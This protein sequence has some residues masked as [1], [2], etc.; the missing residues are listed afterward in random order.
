MN[1]APILFRCDATPDLSW[2]SFYQCMVLANAIQRRRR[3]TWFL[4]RLEP[5]SLAVTI[6]RGGHEWN[7]T[8]TMLGTADDLDATLREIR[9]LSAAAVVVCGH[10]LNEEYLREL[11]AAGVLVVVV[12][13]QAQV[14][15]PN[16]LVINPFLGLGRE[17]YQFE[18]GTQLLLGSRF[19]LVRPLIRRL[20]PIRAQEP[21]Q[22]FR[23]LVV[24]GDDDPTGYTLDVARELL[25]GEGL[26]R[27]DVFVRPHHVRLDELR[28]LAAD[29]P[30]RMDVLTEGPELSA[31]VSRCHFAVTSGD[32]VA[33]ELACVGVP[34]IMT[35]LEPRHLSN[36]I[37]L[38]EEGV[39]TNL[40]L[41]GEVVLDD[42]RQAIQVFLTDPLE[43]QGMARCGR[44]LIDGRGPDRLVTALE[45]LLHP[46]RPVEL[47]MA[48]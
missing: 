33:L 13:N 36:A 23:A 18:R 19:A 22:P 26:G 37:R 12:D 38:D 10:D 11:D 16:R 39:A 8:P 17:R 21:A 48:A 14:C 34:Q 15:F 42:L 43:R 5:L 7:D 45:V 20:R 6:H 32:G 25:Q 30:G 46:A 9:R 27:A 24:L 41:A 44:Q 31:R 1:R 2:E 47:R 40:G 4:S 29:N 35:V 28:A 3:P